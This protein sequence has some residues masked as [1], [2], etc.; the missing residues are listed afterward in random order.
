MVRMK[1]ISGGGGDALF[2]ISRRNRG[3]LAEGWYEPATLQKA[4]QNAAQQ[5]ALDRERA[6]PDYARGGQ[7]QSGEAEDLL[8]DDDDDDEDYGPRLPHPGLMRA[9]ARSGPAI[10]SMQDLELQRG[11]HS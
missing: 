11:K 7:A 3:E 8:A 10:P 4:R 6:S 5:P 1:V 9:A 2:L